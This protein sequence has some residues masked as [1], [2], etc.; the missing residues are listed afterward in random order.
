M[1]G[2][3]TREEI[4]N[5]ST[6]DLITFYNE[7]MAASGG[8]PIKKF[9][10]RKTAKDRCWALIVKQQPPPPVETGEPAVAEGAYQSATDAEFRTG[11]AEKRRAARKAAKTA[12]TKTEKGKK[13][14]TPAKA[15]K[16]SKAAPG[17]RVLI[18]G[19]KIGE[20]SNRHRLYAVLKASKGRWVDRDAAIK[21]VYG[22]KLPASPDGAIRL[23]ASG[24]K[25]AFGQS[26]LKLLIRTRRENNNSQIGL[27]DDKQAELPIGEK[28]K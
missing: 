2:I 3:T 6:P 1:S 17:A 8:K 5:T 23:V 11:V 25:K 9:K 4:E 14:A 24:L 7:A 12:T 20:N 27:F 28:K 13:P 22:D 19:M 15:K 16:G 10:D 18:D 26:E 21:A